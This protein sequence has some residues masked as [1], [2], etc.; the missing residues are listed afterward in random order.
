MQPPEWV[1][2]ATLAV[3]LLGLFA[4]LTNTFLAVRKS[5]SEKKAAYRE[6]TP[7]VEVHVTHRI[8][9]ERQIH[10]KLIVRPASNEVVCELE[11]IELLGQRS[12]DLEARW[13][14]HSVN[15]TGSLALNPRIVVWKASQGRSEQINLTLTQVR[16]ENR[17]VRARLS[18]FRCDA[19]RSRFT[20]DVL[21]PAE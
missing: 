20:I 8:G 17:P 16:R 14:G 15:G 4:T 7:S 5:M 18:G 1:T 11:R 6:M 3:A 9:Q 10:A 19:M 2:Y 13:G 21:L 12:F